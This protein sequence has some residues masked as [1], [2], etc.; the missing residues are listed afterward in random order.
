MFIGRKSKFSGKANIKACEDYEKENGSFASI[1]EEI[2][3]T[4]GTIRIWYLK[5]KE[6]GPDVFETSNR[7]R[8]YAKEFKLSVVEE[9]ISGKG[10]T[11]DLAVKY[12]IAVGMLSDWV[13]KWYNGI[14]M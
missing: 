2:G 7:N 9:Y 14:E 13:N 1:A 5:Y 4:K 6:Y 12:N 3:T 10:S 8:S 11:T